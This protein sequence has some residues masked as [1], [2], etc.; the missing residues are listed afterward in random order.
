MAGLSKSPLLDVLS[1][2]QE[3][4]ESNPTSERLF[5]AVDRPLHE[6]IQD[7][8]QHTD[9]VARFV[10]AWFSFPTKKNKAGVKDQEQIYRAIYSAVM[11]KDA[12]LLLKLRMNREALSFPV[13]NAVVDFEHLLVKAHDNNDA[14]EMI[15]PS[16]MLL[17]VLDRHDH[18]MVMREAI[19][20][21]Y[22]RLIVREAHKYSMTASYLEDITMELYGSLLKAFGRF[23][24][25]S[26]TFTS[27]VLSWARNAYAS[28]L[29]EI[30]IGTAFQIPNAVR[31][32]VARGQSSIVNYAVP[33]NMEYG[34]YDSVNQDSDG[35][36]PESDGDSTD[37]SDT[38]VSTLHDSDSTVRDI[39]KVYDDDGL[40]RS[41]G[42]VEVDMR[43][44]LEGFYPDGIPVEGNNGNIT[45]IPIRHTTKRAEK[46]ARR[47]R[48]IPRP[49]P[50]P[51]KRKA[52]RHGL[53][54]AV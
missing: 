42:C 22:H 45:T 53:R 44:L 21:K 43:Q 30:E 7:L 51:R 11:K 23:D 49:V 6:N 54:A 9:Y 40:L 17:G 24:I 19:V 3:R 50:R 33:M 25:T 36:E 20:E 39:I 29:P 37:G 52:P 27:Y 34:E 10:T 14:S 16:Q 1:S 46:P 35:P 15:M 18:F 5:C 31:I 8:C 13:T 38:L 32:K 2:T 47:E 48:R 4:I 26:G 41:L 28:R 12:S